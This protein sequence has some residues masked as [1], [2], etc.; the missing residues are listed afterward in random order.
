MQTTRRY[1]RTM[2]EAFGPYTSRSICEP[3]SPMALTDKIIVGVS[4]TICLSVFALILL[5]VL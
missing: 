5:G 1:P 3:Y 2:Q 4:L